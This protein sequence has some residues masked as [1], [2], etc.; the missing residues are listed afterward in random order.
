MALFS[1]PSVLCKD[2]NGWLDSHWRHASSWIE[3]C[4][5]SWNIRKWIK[6]CHS[7][8]L[9]PSF[10]LINLN[11]FEILETENRDY[12]RHYGSRCLLLAY[13]LG[14]WASNERRKN[15]NT[16][17]QCDKAS[18]REQEIK[19]EFNLK[20]TQIQILFEKPIWIKKLHRL[21]CMRYWRL[22]IE[23]IFG[24]MVLFMVF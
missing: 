9:K 18:V 12:F 20:R 13:R 24:T 16:I 19:I 5:S 23:T 4:K 10:W 11:V 8:K 22:K 14:I 6:R 1:I 2:S 15:S 17:V 3:C 21:E 7:T